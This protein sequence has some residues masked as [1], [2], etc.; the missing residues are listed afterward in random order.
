MSSRGTADAIFILRQ[1]Q[2]KYLHKKKNIYFT[3][4]DA[5]KALIVYHVMFFG[6]QYRNLE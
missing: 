1:L 4:A 5:E 6:G 3:I 2:E